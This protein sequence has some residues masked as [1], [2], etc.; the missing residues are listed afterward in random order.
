MPVAGNEA[1]KL[2][3]FGFCESWGLINWGAK[4]PELAPEQAQHAP[5]TTLGQAAL[6]PRKRPLDEDDGG[7]EGSMDVDED[8]VWSRHYDIGDARCVDGT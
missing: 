1:D 8:P 3:V 5:P 2:R 4:L 7:E 6:R